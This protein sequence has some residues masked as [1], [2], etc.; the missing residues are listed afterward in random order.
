MAHD[1]YAL[2]DYKGLSLKDAVHEVIWNKIDKMEGS[3]AV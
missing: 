1:I 2:M 3:A